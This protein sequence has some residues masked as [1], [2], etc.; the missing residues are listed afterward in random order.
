L[1][2]YLY[3][4]VTGPGVPP[5]AENLKEIYGFVE[6][7]EMVFMAFQNM[8]MIYQWYGVPNIYADMSYLKPPKYLIINKHFF[9][10]KLK[11]D[12]DQK[13]NVLIMIS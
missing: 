1:V 13:T 5:I 8:N 3:P 4:Y 12:L 7:C 11:F 9:P 6:N 10:L 2:P